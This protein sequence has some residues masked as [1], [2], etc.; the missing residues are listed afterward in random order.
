M[1]RIDIHIDVPQVQY[2]KL[3]GERLGES[4]AAIRERVI[5][6]RQQQAE[7]FAHTRCLTNADMG[8]GVIRQHCALDGAGQSLMKAAMRQLQLSARGY[9]RVLKLARSVADLAGSAAIGPAQGAEALQYR[10]RRVE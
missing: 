10:P 6:A 3:S 9:H 8:A 4:S 5:A 1:D 2:E 7:R